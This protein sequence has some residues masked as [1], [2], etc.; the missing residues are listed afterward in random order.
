[1]II[2]LNASNTTKTYSTRQ[3]AREATHNAVRKYFGDNARLEIMT[4]VDDHEQSP[5]F[6]CVTRILGTDADMRAAAELARNGFYV[7]N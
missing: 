1:M 6:Y 3:K 4:C 7:I 5:R 2:Y